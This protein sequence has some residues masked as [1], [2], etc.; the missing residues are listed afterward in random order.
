MTI[1][2][3]ETA[4]R[5]NQFGGQGSIV[6]S[7]TGMIAVAQQREVAEIQ[8]AMI[9]ARTNPRN[10]LEAMDRILQACT[11]ASLAESAL[12]SYARGGTDITGPSIRLAEMLAQNWQNIDFGIRE[13]EQRD[14][15]STVEAYAWD[16]QNN[17]RQRKVFHVPHIRYSRSKGNTVLTDPRD[18]YE[19]VANQGAR[20]LRTCILGV[21]PGD[22]IEAA[23]KQ[24][25]VTLATK[26]EVT[27]ERIK[28]LITE[29]AKYSVTKEM[30]EKRIQR[31]LEA[32]TPA[33]MVQL[34]KVYNSLKD[35]MSVVS[36]WFGPTTAEP[37]KG[38]IS[39]KD[40]KPGKEDNR[41]HDQ[42]NLEKVGTDSL[43][44]VNA[45]KAEVEAESREEDEE[46]KAIREES[47]AP[48][49]KP[50]AKAA[51][52]FDEKSGRPRF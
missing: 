35:G 39:M 46:R 29:F 13:L 38:A 47:A 3:E 11:R 45:Y 43:E 22:V 10:E 14:G 40:L 17:V 8:S 27:P 1:K 18:I 41:G 50:V 21:I 36:D 12:Y 4:N 5:S 25:D 19:M 6:K 30:I 24:C 23:V 9:I 16:I 51:S 28:S 49:R 31:R 20:R 7:D 34:G 44:E 26:A 2:I 52:P 33:L 37:E 48:A 32:M 15:E 42:E